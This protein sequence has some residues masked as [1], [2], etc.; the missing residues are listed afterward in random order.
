GASPGSWRARASPC[1]RDAAGSAARR[2]PRLLRPPP[3][4]SGRVSLR[5]ALPLYPGGARMCTPDTPHIPPTLPEHVLRGPFPEAGVTPRP[6]EHTLNSSHVSISYAVL[7]L[8]KKRGEAA[9]PQRAGR[10]AVERRR[11]GA[12]TP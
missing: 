1:R 5:G 10:E 7:C 8:K 6:E 9:Q 3:R 12:H 4:P 11:D 2:R